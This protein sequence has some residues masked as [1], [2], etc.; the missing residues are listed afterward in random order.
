MAEELIVLKQLPIIEQQLIKV[1]NEID[2]KIENAKS[3]V[4]NEETRKIVK[5]LRASLNKEFTEW[6]TK[7]KEIKEKIMNPYMEFEEAY[8]KYI[9]DKYKIA[10][11]ELKGKID[12]VEDQIKEDLKK[13]A[14]EYFDEYKS[15]KN[16][17]FVK[18]EDMKYAVGLSDNPT[19]LKKLSTEF[20]DK[21][22]KD[23]Q[24]IDTYENKAEMLVEYKKNLD[25][26]NAIIVV[27]NRYKAIE[28][29]KN[30]I[31][32]KEKLQQS[33]NNITTNVEVQK[34]ESSNFTETVEILKAP[35]KVE[36]KELI[37]AVFKI[38]NETKE[39]LLEVK[40]FL[41]DGGYDFE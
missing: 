35:E 41:E 15:S 14:I 9:S 32:V 22:E 20:I 40:K 1:S 38:K 25:L 6:E 29:E 33:E 17:D 39:R 27:Q 8:K 36:N 10:D 28:E 21:V 4:C 12:F 23:L 18:F 16:I 34:I 31:Q 3:L 11:K 2:K 13:I 24:V 5:E 26:N 30:K 19:K 7:R 37:T